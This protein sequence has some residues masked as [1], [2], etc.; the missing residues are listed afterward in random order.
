MSSTGGATTGTAADAGSD[1]GDGGSISVTL[2][3]PGSGNSGT[4][5]PGSGDPGNGNPGSGNTGSGDPGSG[6]AGTGDPGGSASDGGAVVTAGAVAQALQWV[7]AK[8]PYCGGIQ[9]GPD[10]ICGGTCVR[11]G[12]AN[13]PQWNAYRSD[14]SGL[15][16]FAWG[17][18]APGLVT[19]QMAP[20]STARSS[21]IPGTSLQPG[22]ALNS[23][24]HVML[25]QSWVDKSSG[26]ASI[27]EES[28]CGLVAL[29][30]TFTLGVN[31]TPNV[32]LGG[33][34]YYAIRSKGGSL[35]NPAN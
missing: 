17:L 35:V 3:D 21:T 8:M 20:M 27:I 12:A 1:G 15:V 24:E 18:P 13:N 33:T 9:N 23:G 34:T 22:D 19:T 31:D 14:C 10:S 29:V 26:S 25:F 2:G 32:T 16:S 5:T 30:K 28:D 11:T 7:A 4:G 6:A